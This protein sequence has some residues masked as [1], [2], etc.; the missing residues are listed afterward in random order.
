MKLCHTLC[1]SELDCTGFH[2]DYRGAGVK[3]NCKIF[4]GAETGNG[5]DGALCFT[6]EDRNITEAATPVTPAEP[7]PEALIDPG[8]QTDKDCGWYGEKYQ[9]YSAYTLWHTNEGA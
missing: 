1:E 6:K 5:K 8:C 7:E 3:G 4:T 2:Y 9:N